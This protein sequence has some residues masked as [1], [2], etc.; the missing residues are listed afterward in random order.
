[1]NTV[2][3]N[4]ALEL[5]EFLRKRLDDSAEIS[6][7][8]FTECV[9]KGVDF[10]VSRE[11]LTQRAMV[12]VNFIHFAHVRKRILEDLQLELAALLR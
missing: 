8:L 5:Y 3:C 12:S 10:G 4:G 9:N 11:R 7:A 2:D 6:P 1:M